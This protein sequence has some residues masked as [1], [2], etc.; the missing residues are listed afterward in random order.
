MQDRKERVILGDY[1]LRK[2]QYFPI[3]KKIKEEKLKNIVIIGGSH[4]GFSCA[5]MLLH[6]PATYRR[7]T[8]INS[9]FTDQFP[10]A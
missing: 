5:W 8:S 1:F 9:K 10:G 6:G 3:M 4:S 2:E 7:N